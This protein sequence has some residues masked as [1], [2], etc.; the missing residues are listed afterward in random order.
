MEAI[1]QMG[2]TQTM[3]AIVQVVNS[4]LTA[5]ARFHEG[6]EVV[7]VDRARQVRLLYVARLR[8]R[9]GHT[10]SLVLHGEGGKSLC[11]C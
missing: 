5:I 6:G 3:P 10:T 4:L 2:E 7:S 8:A 9:H 1:P 11:Q